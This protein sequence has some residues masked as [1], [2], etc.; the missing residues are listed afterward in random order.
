MLFRSLLMITGI[1]ITASDAPAAVGPA[2]NSAL[3]GAS[4]GEPGAP[5]EISYGRDGYPERGRGR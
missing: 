2:L 4:A 1:V 3:P 5:G